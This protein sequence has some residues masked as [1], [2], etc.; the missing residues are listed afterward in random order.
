MAS[1]KDRYEASRFLA[2]RFAAFKWRGAVSQPNDGWV[3]KT[4]QRLL[5]SQ[6]RERV[7]IAKD[8]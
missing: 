8:R 7:W 6:Q 4:R 5:V 3:A 1:L 2:G